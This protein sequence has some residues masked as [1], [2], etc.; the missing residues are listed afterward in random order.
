MSVKEIHREKSPLYID[1]AWNPLHQTG[2]TFFC[3]G[4]D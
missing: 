2:K 4:D 3:V 1:V